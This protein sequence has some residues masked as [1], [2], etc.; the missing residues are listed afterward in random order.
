MIFNSKYHRYD[1]H[2]EQG[3]HLCR[4][5]LLHYEWHADGG[6][7]HSRIVKLFGR[8]HLLIFD[9][10]IGH[11]DFAQDKADNAVVCYLLVALAVSI[12]KSSKMPVLVVFI[13]C[14][15]KSS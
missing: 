8:L 2:A 14:V 12:E 4:V 9:F 1:K 3:Y 6:R 13:V 7:V 10:L 15:K 5:N 11:W